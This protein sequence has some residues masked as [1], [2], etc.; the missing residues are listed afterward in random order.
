MRIFVAAFL[1]SVSSLRAEPP[2]WRTYT[3]LGWGLTQSDGF[4]RQDWGLRFMFLIPDDSETKPRNVDGPSRFY[5]TGLYAA[6]GGFRMQFGVAGGGGMMLS[7]LHLG[8]F[9]ESSTTT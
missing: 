4:S 6:D 1:L 8:L 3:Y 9:V 2:S 7:T 5:E